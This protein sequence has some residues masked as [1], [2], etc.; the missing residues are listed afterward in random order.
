MISSEEWPPY[1]PDLNSMDYSVWSILWSLGL[2]LNRTK[3]WTLKQSLL[4]EWDG[5]KAI[6]PSKIWPAVSSCTN[7]LGIEDFFSGAVYVQSDNVT[8]HL[9]RCILMKLTMSDSLYD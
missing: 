2:A 5:L 7:W 8:A 9:I 1:T 3:L 4:R 6:N